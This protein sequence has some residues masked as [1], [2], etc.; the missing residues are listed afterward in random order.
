MRPRLSVAAVIEFMNPWGQHGRVVAWTMRK[1][2]CQ[3]MFYMR[4][5][6]PFA[7]PHRS[8]Y[9][10]TVKIPLRFRL[11]SPEGYTASIEVDGGLVRDEA[12]PHAFVQMRREVGQ[13]APQA[14]HRQCGTRGDLN[15]KA[16]QIIAGRADP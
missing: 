1:A 3:R 8:G 10:S 12:K 13:L 16:R 5:L 14:E 6:P 15:G 9:P 2:P 11:L 4:R 7:Q